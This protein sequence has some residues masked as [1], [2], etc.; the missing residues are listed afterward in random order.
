HLQTPA[1]RWA[2]DGAADPTDFVNRWEYLRDRFVDIRKG[3]N[4]RDFPNQN[5][6]AVAAQRLAADAGIAGLDATLAADRAAVRN[7]AGTGWIQVGSADVAAVKANASSLT[8]GSETGG[9]YHFRKHLDELPASAQAAAA[10][11]SPERQFSVYLGD[12]R[13]TIRDGVGAVD[14]Q[15]ARNLIFTR[16][17]T[18]PGGVTRTMTT[19]VVVR[20]GWALITT[21]GGKVQ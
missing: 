12:A 3:L 11:G 4:P 20:D 13:R 5:L 18:E 17:V 9:A 10:Q 16:T 6:D 14:A 2:A 8:F 7:M 19:R 21:H 1:V 15:D